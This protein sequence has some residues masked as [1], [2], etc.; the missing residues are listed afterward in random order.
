MRA[1][2]H[3]SCWNRE[4][5]LGLYSQETGYKSPI[6]NRRL[7]LLEEGNTYSVDNM[8]FELQSDEEDLVKEKDFNNADERSRKQQSSGGNLP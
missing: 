2:P 8:D 6:V 7:H 3:F 5:S 4:R 1:S